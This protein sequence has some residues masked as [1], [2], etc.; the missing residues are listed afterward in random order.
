VDDAPRHFTAVE[1]Q[2][3]WITGE[4]ASN[5]VGVSGWVEVERADGNKGWVPANAVEKI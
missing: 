2:K 1:G 4:R 5:M 3:L